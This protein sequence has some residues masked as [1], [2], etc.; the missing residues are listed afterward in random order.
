MDAE[1][2]SA[3]GGHWWNRGKPTVN[4]DGKQVSLEGQTLVDYF[5]LHSVNTVHWV[6]VLCWFAIVVMVVWVFVNAFKVADT[7]T[8]IWAVVH[9]KKSFTQKEGLQWLGASTDVVRGDYENNQDS[10]AERAAKRDSTMTD[11]SAPPAAPKATF[12]MREKMTPEEEAIKKM[13]Q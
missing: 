7:I 8:N 9:G 5:L 6:K 2:F 11:M 3:D 1:M 12:M 10:L 13:A 4:V